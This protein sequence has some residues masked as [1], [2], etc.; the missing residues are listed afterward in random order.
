MDIP[1]ISMNMSQNA[2][3]TAVNTELLSLSLDT[4]EQAGTQMTEM[5]ESAGAQ[6]VSA[7]HIDVLI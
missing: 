5:I 4:I 6:V 3:M 2:L 7:D 1:K